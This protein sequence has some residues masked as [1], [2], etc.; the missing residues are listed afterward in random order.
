MIDPLFG[1][2]SIAAAFFGGILAL[3]APCCLTFLLPSYLAAGV[4]HGRWQLVRMTLTF[5]A[6][7]SLVLLPVAWG[8]AGLAQLLPQLHRELFFLGGLLLIGLGALSLTGRWSL[9][10][11]WSPR[12]GPPSSASVFA[13]GAFSGAA[14]S[15][16]A[17]VLAGV[18]ALSVVAPTWWVAI[19]IGL[20]YVFGMVFPLLLVA[21]F[22]Q[23]F[24]LLSHPALRPRPLSLRLGARRWTVTTTNLAAALL[25]WAMGAL[26]LWLGFT[27]E[28]TYSPE[29]LQGVYLWLRG[30]F[31]AVT[32]RLG[33]F[34]PVVVL[35]AAALVLLLILRA[36]SRRE[37]QGSEVA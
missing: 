36:P 4:H 3:L 8:I 7:L 5:S 6:G 2:A 20:A 13:L 24:D 15:C 33:G 23:R 35:A 21:L 34:S 37:Q 1:S 25:L 29:F 11:P 19:G 18:L 16:C 14:S 27:G 30:V 26:V 10:M 32:D 12:L 9:P 31:D 17:P 28:S 22:G